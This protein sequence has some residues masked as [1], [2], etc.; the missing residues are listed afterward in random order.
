[1]H[2][3]GQIEKLD[4]SGACNEGQGVAIRGARRTRMAGKVE[5]NVAAVKIGIGEIG[6]G[7]ED[8]R[9]GDVWDIRKMIPLK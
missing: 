8:L 6:V 4:R 7:P 3:G 5:R 2:P 1:M 9:D